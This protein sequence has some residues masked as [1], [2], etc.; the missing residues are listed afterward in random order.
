MRADGQAEDRGSH[1][2]C[3]GQSPEVGGQRGV[4]VSELGKTW[5]NPNWHGRRQ[6]S[7]V[8]IGAAEV[9]RNRIMDEG[10]NA[11]VGE[12]LLQKV[13]PGMAVDLRCAWLWI[14]GDEADASFGWFGWGCQEGLQ[15]CPD[16]A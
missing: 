8:G 4:S 2:L 16:G 1:G 15:L 5:R 3:Q 10:L 9:G 13:A 11:V 12:V 7:E 6:R 14:V